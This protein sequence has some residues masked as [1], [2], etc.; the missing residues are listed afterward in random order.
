M[1]VADRAAVN[2]TDVRMCLIAQKHFF[3]HGLP[4]G[5]VCNRVFGNGTQVSGT[6]QL[7]QRVPMIAITMMISIS[8]KPRSL[9]R[10]FV[11][12]IITNCCKLCLRS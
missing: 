5:F 10:A 4:I 6:D 9:V 11:K 2:V 12:A 7:I 1:D 3:R 8:V